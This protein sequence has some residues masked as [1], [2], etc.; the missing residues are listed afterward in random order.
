MKIEIQVKVR[1]GMRAKIGVSH[2]PKKGKGS[3]DRK[4]NGHR[5]CNKACAFGPIFDE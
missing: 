5:S 2:K 4:K 1:K 3:Y